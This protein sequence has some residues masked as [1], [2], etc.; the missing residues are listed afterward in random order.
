MLKASEIDAQASPERIVYHCP[1][2]ELEDPRV[3]L[4]TGALVVT[5]LADGGAQTDVSADPSGQC[6]APG[7]DDWIPRKQL[8]QRDVGYRRNAGTAVVGLYLV[9]FAGYRQAK[10]T[11]SGGHRVAGHINVFAKVTA[12]VA[13]DIPHLETLR[14]DLDYFLN[15][16]EKLKWQSGSFR[17]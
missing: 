5:L 16:G 2:S 8:A 6:D 17:D 15:L 12:T 4:G 1:Q 7:A 11:A 13:A 10:L 3:L 9:D 14:K